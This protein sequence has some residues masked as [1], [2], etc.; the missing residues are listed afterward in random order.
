[1]SREKM[2]RAVA[3]ARTAST[4]EVDRGAVV[5]QLHTCRRMAGGLNATLEHEFADHGISGL[6]LDRPTLRQL[7]AYVAAHAVDYVI[8]A[9]ASRLARDHGLLRRVT[10][11]LHTHHI[12]IVFADASTSHD[13]AV[14]ATSQGEG[15]PHGATAVTPWRAGPEQSRQHKHSRKEGPHANARNGCHRRFGT[16]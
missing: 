13:M 6:T 3:Y 2:R 16:F 8:C 9:D 1:M 7:L 14:L 4:R 5:S 12:R 15:E 10:R 11:R